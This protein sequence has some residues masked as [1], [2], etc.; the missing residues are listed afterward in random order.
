VAQASQASQSSLNPNPNPNLDPDLDPDL[1]PPGSPVLFLFVQ[2]SSGAEER[3]VVRAP[4]KRGWP[5]S[6]RI[7]QKLNM[8]RNATFFGFFENLGN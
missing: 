1:F 8:L 3:T 2:G 4:G 5:F 6:T 7:R